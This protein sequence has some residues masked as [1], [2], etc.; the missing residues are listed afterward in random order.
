MAPVQ[1]LPFGHIVCRAQAGPRSPISEQ[2]QRKTHT[3]LS[4]PDPPQRTEHPIQGDDNAESIPLMS[5]TY[6]MRGFQFA[7]VVLSIWWILSKGVF[8]CNNTQ[9]F[10]A[11][12]AWQF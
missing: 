7:V 5:N 6:V 8:L 11:L 4:F 12:L 2:V 9:P 3:S 10:W 1:N